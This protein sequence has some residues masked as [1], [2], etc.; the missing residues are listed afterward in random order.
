MD[1]TV[2]LNFPATL[3]KR[4]TVLERVANSFEHPKKKQL[5]KTH[6]VHLPREM[7]N[8]FDFDR[9]AIECMTTSTLDIDRKITFS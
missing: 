5:K 2:W 8:D 3:H 4:T 1:Q 6:I 9:I 7:I